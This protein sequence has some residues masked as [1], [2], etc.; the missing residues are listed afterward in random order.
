MRPP[1]VREARKCRSSLLVARSSQN[2]LD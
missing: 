1:L 2:H